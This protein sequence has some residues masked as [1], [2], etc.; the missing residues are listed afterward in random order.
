MCTRTRSRPI[1]LLYF[2]PCRSELFAR[3][4][5][6]TPVWYGHPRGQYS[7]SHELSMVDPLIRSVTSRGAVPPNAARRSET[8]RNGQEVGFKSAWGGRWVFVFVPSFHVPPC[9]HPWPP[10]SVPTSFAFLIISPYSLSP[11]LSQSI[12]RARPRDTL[13]D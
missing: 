5:P 6:C 7:S 10:T 9:A 4:D 13:A 2:S 1:P 11:S 8:A 3:S 12:H